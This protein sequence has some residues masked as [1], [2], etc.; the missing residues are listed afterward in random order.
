[1]SRV[2]VQGRTDSIIRSASSFMYASNVWLSMNP[3]PYL[4][5]VCGPIERDNT[6]EEEGSCRQTVEELEKELLAA[7]AEAVAIEEPETST[8]ARG[9]AKDVDGTALK[10]SLRSGTGVFVGR[11]DSPG[12][13][14][15]LCEGT[16][17]FEGRDDSPDLQAVV[18]LVQKVESNPFRRLR[19]RGRMRRAC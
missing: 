13:G 14:L 4:V 6:A 12:V 7:P 1:M 9:D 8:D 17:V 5:D 10:A 18:A 16:G 19:S 2:R 11:E 3:N 15:C